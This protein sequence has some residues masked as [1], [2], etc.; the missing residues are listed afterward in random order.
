MESTRRSF[1]G[2]LAGL[3][4][5]PAVARAM[6]PAVDDPDLLDDDDWSPP[7][8]EPIPDAR[9]WVGGEGGDWNDPRNWSDGVLP[10]DGDTVVIENGGPTNPPPPGLM[11]GCLV[12]GESGRLTIDRWFNEFVKMPV[13]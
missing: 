4:G 8:S 12:V 2:V 5:L 10:R 7:P 9:R 3:V 6:P 11:L 1:F 13:W